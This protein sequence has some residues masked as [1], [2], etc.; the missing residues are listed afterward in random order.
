MAQYTRNITLNGTGSFQISGSGF[1]DTYNWNAN[2]RLNHVTV[3]NDTAADS[4]TYNLSLTGGAWR[5]N[6]LRLSDVGINAKITDSNDGVVRQIEALRLGD[7]GTDLTLYATR[8]RHITGFDTE[9]NTLRMGSSRTTSIELHSGNDVVIGGSGRIT[10]VALGDGNDRFTAGTGG[11]NLVQLGAGNDTMAGGSGTRVGL[12]DLGAGNDR[13]ALTHNAQVDAING[14]EGTKTITLAATSRIKYLEIDNAV[15]KITASANAKI[16]A[17]KINGGALELKTAAGHLETLN[18]WNA[19]TKLTI[20]AGGVGT[21]YLTGDAGPHSITVAGS[22]GALQATTPGAVTLSVTGFADA[23]RTGAGADRI[24]TGDFAGSVRTMDG[25]DI[26]VLGKGGA[27]LINLGAGDDILRISG[28]NANAGVSAQG[29]AGVDTLDFTGMAATPVHVSL[30]AVGFQSIL[31]NGSGDS[32]WF[33]VSG[34]ENVIGGR[35][36][37]SLTGDAGDNLLSGAAGVD[38]LRGGEGNDTLIGGAGAD[39]FVFA[40]GGGRDRITDFEL[41]VDLLQFTAASSMADVRIT[42]NGANAIVIV[43]NASVIVENV[44][45]ADLLDADNF[46]F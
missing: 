9:S 8:V 5:I 41:G 15:T 6:A 28:L 1:T 4:Y 45:R 16:Q 33:N 17:A 30:A 18:V 11:T 43:G 32:G 21:I 20:G 40:P 14:Y 42:A 3:W 39:V 36:A 2:Q 44:T 27:G 10:S 29:G 12:L 22:L 38:T 23:I 35:G 31:R 26:V 19:T 7:A 24:T 34:F 25:D 13:V 37:D 46:L